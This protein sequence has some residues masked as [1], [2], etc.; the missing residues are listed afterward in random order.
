MGLEGVFLSLIASGVSWGGLE[1]MLR[2]TDQ[3]KGFQSPSKAPFCT[4]ASSPLWALSYIQ[5]REL[6]SL[7]KSGLAGL[8]ASIL[9]E[10]AREP[11]T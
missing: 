5:F 7:W 8:A 3:P 11:E 6:T 10:V 9:P 1:V 2:R 4:T